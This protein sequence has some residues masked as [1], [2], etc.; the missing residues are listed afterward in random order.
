MPANCR[1]Q[2]PFRTVPCPTMLCALWSAASCILVHLAHV[3]LN[4]RSHVTCHA[5]QAKCLQQAAQSFAGF[6]ES[7]SVHTLARDVLRL[8][9]FTGH[10]QQS[11]APAELELGGRQKI[12]P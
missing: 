10:R 1:R 7:L 4:A 5:F 3:I 12:D 6:A 2:P 8:C 9:P 11:A